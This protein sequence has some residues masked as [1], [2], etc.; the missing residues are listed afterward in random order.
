MKRRLSS[1]I[2]VIYAVA[3][4]LLTFFLYAVVKFWLTGVDEVKFNGLP[5][6]A[7]AALIVAVMAVIA[8]RLVAHLRA[9]R[10]ATLESASNRTAE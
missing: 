7:G 4:L 9:Q 8:V 5:P 1:A 6:W 2:V 3:L 10:R